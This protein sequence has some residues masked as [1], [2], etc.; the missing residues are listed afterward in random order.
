MP[1]NPQE[2]NVGLAADIGTL[3]RFPKIVGND[4]KAREMALTGRRFGAEEAREIGFVGNVVQGGRREVVGE[5]IEVKSA[6]GMATVM[7]DKGVVLGHLLS[8]ENLAC[9]L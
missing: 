1:D 5:S 4:S 8:W 3:Q 9:R 6:T 7:R 2:V